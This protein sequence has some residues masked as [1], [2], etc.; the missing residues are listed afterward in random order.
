MREV[1]NITYRTMSGPDIENWLSIKFAE[2]GR[3]YPVS[4]PYLWSVGVIIFY[5][6]ITAKNRGNIAVHSIRYRMYGLSNG[7]SSSWF[8]FLGNN[9][10]PPTVRHNVETAAPSTPSLRQ[11]FFLL[12]YTRSSYT[13]LAV[14]NW[15]AV[16]YAEPRWTRLCG[17]G[18]FYS[19]HP[20]QP[21][22]CNNARETLSY[23]LAAISS[24]NSEPSSNRPPHSRRTEQEVFHLYSLYS[25]G[26]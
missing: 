17:A 11:S 9:G 22:Y 19:S 16:S 7:A 21:I 6:N 25:F 3:A 10:L 18:E 1:R 13:G 8:F 24:S 23:L 15:E 26:W 5:N 14:V 12:S 4:W 20:I 2:Y